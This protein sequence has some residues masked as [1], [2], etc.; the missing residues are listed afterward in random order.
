V[1]QESQITTLSDEL[2]ATNQSK[3]D[4]SQQFVRLQGQHQQLT[5]DHA[6]TLQ[7]L[8]ETKQELQTTKT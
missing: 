6:S 1:P 2:S 4:I 5:A 3:E 7:Q 8:Q